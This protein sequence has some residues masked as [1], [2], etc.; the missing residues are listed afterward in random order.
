MRWHGGQ[1]RR[2]R[3]YRNDHQSACRSQGQNNRRDTHCR[4]LIGVSNSAEPRVFEKPWV[5]NPAYFR[6]IV[7]GV[8][9]YFGITMGIHGGMAGAI[10]QESSPISPNPTHSVGYVSGL[11][12]LDESSISGRWVNNGTGTLVP[13]A[14]VCD[15]QSPGQ[16]SLEANVSM[17]EAT[18]WRA[19]V[20]AA[21]PEALRIATEMEA[22][23]IAAYGQTICTVLQR[24]TSMDDVRLTQ[25]D[26]DFPAAFDAAV[27]VAAI[28]TYCPEQATEIGR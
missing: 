26:G 2:Q 1:K 9:F 22:G 21:S 28:H 12:H 25:M 7:L 3:H 16:T 11:C 15:A 8:A 19:F 20:T 27:N 10:A 6:D 13:L 18:F 17:E 23:A 14:T 4:L 24:G 5:L